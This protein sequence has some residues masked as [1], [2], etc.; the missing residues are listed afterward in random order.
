MALSLKIQSEIHNL[1]TTSKL[2]D[3]DQSK[4]KFCDEN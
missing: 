4:S 3:D 1:Y 2:N